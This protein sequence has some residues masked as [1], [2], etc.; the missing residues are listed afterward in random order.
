MSDASYI[1]LDHNATTPVDTRVLDTMLP[2]FTQ[3]F[4]NAASIDHEAGHIAKR[5]VETAREQ[6]AA[7]LHASDPKEI[8]FTSGATES[9]NIALFGVVEKYADKGDH[10]ITCVTEHKAILDCCKRLEQMG[11]RV[12]YLPVDQY[13]M[14]DLDALR[15]AIT[16]ETIL[17]SI[18][19]ANNEIG[20]IA[21]VSEIG[22]IAHEHGILF[23]TDAAQAVGH[24]PVDV[25]A[26]NIDLLSFSAHKT[27]GPK[28]IGALYVRRRNPRV[29]VAPVIYGGGHELGI[30]SGTLNVPGIVGMGKALEIAKAEMRDEAEKYRRW[31]QMMF[32]QLR[33]QLGEVEL[34]GHP[35]Q[36]LP[37]NLNVSIKGIES[38]SLIVQLKNIALSTGS[39]CTSASVEA[40]HVILALGFGEDRA[41][42]A[43]RIGFGRTN[44]DD[45]ITFILQSIIEK[46]QQLATLHF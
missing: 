38:R 12:T 10:I 19:F 8:I 32:Q 36:R 34:N 17:I 5:A 15:Q 26:M 9:D 14:V 18:M 44:T 7:I 35:T 43:I 23:H 46:C 1:Y 31:T 24:V 45:H 41:H 39:A 30:R 6:C 27:Y 4:G 40:S 28:G 21:P 2:Y 13:G 42:N 22:A 16:P 20:T 3:I 33:E 37:H 11:K 25:E 29:K